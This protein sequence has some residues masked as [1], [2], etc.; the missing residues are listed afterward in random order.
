M[1][2][3]GSKSKPATT[4]VADTPASD[5]S[6]QPTAEASPSVDTAAKDMPDPASLTPTIYFEFDSSNLSEEARNE[7]NENAEWLR[8]DPAR[9]LTIEGHTDPVGTDEYNLG[10]G[11]RRAR[12]VKDYLVRLGIADKRIEIITYGEERPASDEDAKNR[13]AVFVSQR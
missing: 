4:T 10:L 2:G 8:E 5:T 1:I 9:T 6:K 12:A 13:R 11:E 7:L 3:C